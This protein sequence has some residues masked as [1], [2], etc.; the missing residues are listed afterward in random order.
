MT[1]KGT[2]YH[3]SPQKSNNAVITCGER[4]GA[5]QRNRKEN[6][7]RDMALTQEHGVLGKC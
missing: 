7:P 3:R 5:R 2:G 6:L 1:E 4:K